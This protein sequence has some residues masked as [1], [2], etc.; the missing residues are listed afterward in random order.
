MAF[1]SDR[2]SSLRHS[3]ELGSESSAR[4][5][6]PHGADQP[7]EA[8]MAPGRKASRRCRRAGSNG[9]V[10]PMKTR[11]EPKIRSH[12]GNEVAGIVRFTKSAS[13]RRQL[14]G[15]SLIEM[16]VYIGLLMLLV[17]IGSIASLRCEQ[18]SIAMRRNVDDIAGA[19]RA[20]EQWRADVR[21]ARGPLSLA[22]SPVEQTLRWQSARG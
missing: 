15:F 10:N 14:R 16:L 11:S 22:S 20:G 7:G 13:S 8:G 18:S 3:C 4:T 6:P 1:V 2:H 21:S 12:R 9:P 19:L 17:G 5:I